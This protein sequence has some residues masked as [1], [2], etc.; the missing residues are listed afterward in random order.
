MKACNAKRDDMLELLDVRFLVADAV[1]E[2]RSVAEVGG[3]LLYEGT[4]LED[5]D[6]QRDTHYGLWAYEI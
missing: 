4:W 2:D 6:W 3:A 5:V 1:D